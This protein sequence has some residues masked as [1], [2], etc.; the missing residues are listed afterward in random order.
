MVFISGNDYCQVVLKKI[1]MKMTFLQ[2]VLLR[3][4][5]MYI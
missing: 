2:F 5:E 4:Y 3:Y 1:L